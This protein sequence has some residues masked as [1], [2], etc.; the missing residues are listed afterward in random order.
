MNYI[1]ALAM[2]HQGSAPYP[3]AQN[4]SDPACFLTLVTAAGPQKVAPDAAILPTAAHAPTV[5]G[6]ATDGPQPT[7]LGPKQCEI[8]VALDALCGFA[9]DATVTVPIAQGQC[10]QGSRSEIVSRS[11]YRENPEL[12]SEYDRT[13]VPAPIAG[14][15]SMTCLPMPT[16]TRQLSAPP[17]NGTASIAGAKDKAETQFPARLALPLKPAVFQI[18]D[19][20]SW[21]SPSSAHPVPAAAVVA[22]SL[23]LAP[24]LDLAHGDLWLDQ[25]TREI[26]AFAAHDGSLRFRLSPPALGQLDIAIHNDGDGVSIQL[27]PNTE[28][29]TRIFAAEQ[30]K[31]VEELR[32]YGVRLSDSDLLAGHHGQSHREHAHWQNFMQPHAEQPSPHA[33]S[34]PHA[35][36]P[37]RERDDGRFA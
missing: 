34:E 6:A 20:I 29:A 22:P 15:V 32:Q 10:I 18:Q 4:S 1:P 37:R 5:P 3:F 31:L 14:N 24:M 13:D 2:T 26:M 35:D 33:P 27:Q 12:Q 30:P 17:A 28:A 16:I 36:T 7:I 19:L 11:E 25:L 21:T 9:A 8:S 23:A